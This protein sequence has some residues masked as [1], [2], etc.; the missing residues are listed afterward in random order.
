MHLDESVLDIRNGRFP[1]LGRYVVV[2][3]IL[4]QEKTTGLNLLLKFFDNS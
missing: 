1:R 3:S 2:P 4:L